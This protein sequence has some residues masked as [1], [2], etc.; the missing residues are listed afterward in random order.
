M[1][2]C[3]VVCMVFCAPPDE[4]GHVRFQA[5]R[6][7]LGEYPENTMAAYRASW[8]LHALPEIDIR[9]TKDGV[10]VCLHDATLARTSNAPEGVKDADIAR[11]TFDEVRAHDVGAWF[12]AEFAGEKVPALR[13][14]F[15]EMRGKP[16]RHV[17]LD[18]KE[19]DLPAL[20][21]LIEDY[22]V[23]SQIIFC[24]NRQEN[25]ISMRER[26]PGL[27][28]MLWIGGK[29]DEIMAMFREA[30]ESGFKGLDQVQLHLAVASKEDGIRYAIP[31]SFIQSA[32]AETRAQGLDLEV[33]PFAFD[34][35]SIHALLDLGVRWFATDHPNRFVAC[36]PPDLLGE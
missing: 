11:L 26:V 31:E 10:I 14:V 18:L 7:G 4:A 25:C 17:Y 9:T 23:A 24:H 28:T 27:R 29:P 6:G 19:V 5:H 22:G 36:I 12:D 34:E 21:R 2:L 16:D 3:C 1:S 33:L 35:A 20:A 32:L 8:S 13:D 15:A 30:A